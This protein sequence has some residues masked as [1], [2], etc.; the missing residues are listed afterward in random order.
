ML[1][2]SKVTPFQDSVLALFPLLLNVI[3][4]QDISPM[5]LFDQVRNDVGGVSNFMEALDCLLA[6]GKI[7]LNEQTEFLSY[8]N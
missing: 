3:K 1:L 2:P 4:V 7:K 6:L 5:N 8:V